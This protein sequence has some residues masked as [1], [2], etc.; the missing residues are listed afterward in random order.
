MSRLLY[1]CTMSLDGFI[2]GPGGD[3]S[4]L[5]SHL[6]P[7]PTVDRLIPRIGA[8]LV[9][10]RT[11]GGDDPHRGTEREGK[12]FGGGWEGPQFVLTNRPPERPIPGVTFVTD[13]RQAVDG[14]KAAAGE[15]YV[16][17]LGARTARGCVEAGLLDEILVFVA[18]VLLGDGVRLFEHPG[19][20]NVRLERMDVAQTPQATS[21]WFRVVR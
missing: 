20:T 18:P 14:A 2:A 8:L 1:S 13:L 19:G 21:L 5:T 6:G 4:W 9:G 15:K 10:N 17:V 16:N 11:F 7:N 12:A 3:M